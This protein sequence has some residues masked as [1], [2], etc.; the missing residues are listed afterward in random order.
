MLHATHP[1]APDE[2]RYRVR[3]EFKE[4]IARRFGVLYANAKLSRRL[5]D[6]YRDLFAPVTVSPSNVPVFCWP[7]IELSD[8]WLEPTSEDDESANQPTTL[9]DA[10]WC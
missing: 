3:P 8:D 5:S 9:A 10:P 6:S 4:F 2:R 1:Q 7:A